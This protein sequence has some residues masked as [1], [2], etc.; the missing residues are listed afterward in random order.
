MKN[1]FLLLSACAVFVLATGFAGPEGT[2]NKYVGTSACKACHNMDK[3]GKQFAAW[4]K[5]AH[6]GAFK[7]LTTPAADKIAKD[8]GLSTKAAE[9]KECLTC[10]VSGMNVKGAQFDAKFKQED[11]VG[12]E[13]CHGAGSGFKS[14]HAK[15][16]NLDKAKAAGMELPSVADGSAEK[17]CKSCHNDKSPTNKAFNFKESWKKIAHPLP[18]G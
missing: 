4:E 16:E 14:L 3:T 2:D 12:C 10:H 5:S 15:K 7:T 9:S 17:L 11:G 8:K 1:M 18:K 6:A 13:A